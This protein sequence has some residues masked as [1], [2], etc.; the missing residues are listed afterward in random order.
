MDI[1]A[2][3]VAVGQ[4]RSARPAGDRRRVDD[5]QAVL[6]GGFGRLEAGRRC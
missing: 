6:V 3:E 5:D 1:G 2:D 4:K